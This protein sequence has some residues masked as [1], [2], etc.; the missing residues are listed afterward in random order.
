MECLWK[1]QLKKLSKIY[2]VPV[3]EAHKLP[4]LDYLGFKARCAALQEK[5]KWKVDLNLCHS[6][7]EVLYK[8]R[9]TKVE[10]LRQHMPFVKK[11]KKV[12]RPAK[13][14]KKDGTL[15]VDGAKWQLLLRENNL[16]PDYEGEVSVL[17]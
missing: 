12:K 6:T 5:S 14:Y 4:I 13:P 17:D 16:Q 3:V 11:Y 7:L 1:N 10:G 2:S 8:E 9:D 15:S